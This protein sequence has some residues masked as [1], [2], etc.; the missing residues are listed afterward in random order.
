MIVSRAVFS[1]DN[2]LRN[3]FTECED[4]FALADLA[5]FLQPEKTLYCKFSQCFPFNIYMR[6]GCTSL[7]LLRCSVLS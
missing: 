3:L 2:N 5:F 1:P 4:A 7:Q 6:L